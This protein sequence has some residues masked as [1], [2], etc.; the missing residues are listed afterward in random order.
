MILTKVDHSVFNRHSSH[1]KHIFLIVYVDDIVIT[2]DDY[3]DI[4]QLKQHL[5]SHF[6]T[7]DLG[8]LNYFM[9]IEVAQSS[10]GIAITQGN[11]P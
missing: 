7:M 4:A 3:E 10:H 5:S 9:G 2:G 8:M 1:G 11:M 6:Q